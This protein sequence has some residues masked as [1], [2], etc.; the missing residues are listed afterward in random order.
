MYVGDNDATT[1]LSGSFLYAFVLGD[2][3]HLYM[4][5]WQGNA[6]VWRDQGVPATNVKAVVGA[7]TLYFGNNYVSDITKS[8]LYVFVQGDDGHLYENSYGGATWAW[9]DRRLQGVEC[10]L[11]EALWE[12]FTLGAA[13]LRIFRHPVFMTLSRDAMETCTTALGKGVPG[14]GRTK[15]PSP[16]GV[17][18]TQIHPY[19]SWTSDATY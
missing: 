12:P 2:N 5:S 14:P 15:E 11:P 3:G 17:R 19:G 13:I 16:E 10:R 18:G 4:K 8:R 1:N 9:N 7:G 6:W